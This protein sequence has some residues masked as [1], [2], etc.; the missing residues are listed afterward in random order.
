MALTRRTGVVFLCVFAY[1]AW[2]AAS[3]LVLV[4]NDEGIYLDGGLR[5]LHGQ[6]P[7]KDFFSLTGP[8]TFVLEALSLRVFGTTLM[9]GRMPVVWDIAILAACLF[10]LVSKLSNSITAA[11]ASFTFLAFATL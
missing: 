10:W 4:L 11:F 1:L 3:R 8:G 2:L 7:Y 9:A 6:I 5:I